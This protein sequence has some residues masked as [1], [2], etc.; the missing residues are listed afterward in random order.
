MNTEVRFAPGRQKSS[1]LLDF[2]DRAVALGVLKH[3]F[4]IFLYRKVAVSVT[5]LPSRL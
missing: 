5:H 1:A 3:Q 4:S 2:G